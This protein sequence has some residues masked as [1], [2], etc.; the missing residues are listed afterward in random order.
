[1]QVSSEY[2]WIKQG[3]PQ[4]HKQIDP[5]L[6]EMDEVIIQQPQ[7]DTT[8]ASPPKRS[9]IPPRNVKR[10]IGYGR[11]TVLIASLAFRNHFRPCF[12]NRGYSE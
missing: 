12:L 8:K 2:L 7:Q 9:T 5:A 4:L 1:M 6:K 10:Y 11:Y 3:P